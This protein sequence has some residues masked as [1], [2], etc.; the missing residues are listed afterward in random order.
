VKQT[1]IDVAMSKHIDDRQSYGYENNT[2]QERYAH[3]FDIQNGN[4]RVE[5]HHLTPQA[6]HLARKMNPPKS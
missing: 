4:V 1:V 2:M 6:Y 5:D 3:G